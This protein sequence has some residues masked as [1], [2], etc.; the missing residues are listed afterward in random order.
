VKWVGQGLAAL[1]AMATAALSLGL[2]PHP[3][4]ELVTVAIAGAGAVYVSP[5]VQTRCPQCG[6]VHGVSDPPSTGP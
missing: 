4:A 2:L 6:V 1:L 3:W 5:R